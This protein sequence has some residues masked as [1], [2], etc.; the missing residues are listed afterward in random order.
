[1]PTKRELAG[2]VAR[3]RTLLKEKDELLMQ[4]AIKLENLIAAADSLKH[5]RDE[6][7]EMREE[8]KRKRLRRASQQTS[9]NSRR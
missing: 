8:S 7:R 4:A 1:M 3:L 6:L 9:H 5:S 2:Q